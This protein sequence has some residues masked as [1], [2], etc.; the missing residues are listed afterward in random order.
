MTSTGQTLFDPPN[1]AGWPGDKTSSLWLNSGTWMTRLN[2]IN[3]LLLRGGGHAGA[4]QP[5]DLQGI[6]NQNH[7]DS[8]EHF[9]D[10]FT[11]FLLDGKL[12]QDR[13][14]PLVDYFTTNDN[15]KKRVRRIT[16]TN[17]KSYPIN[18]VR[19]ALYLLMGLPEYQLN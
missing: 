13:K 19:G 11:S 1:V 4:Y 5:L 16:L 8:P 10:Y 7:I 3:Q 6:V 18:R 17:G 15:A 14:A 9:V 2:L 12:D